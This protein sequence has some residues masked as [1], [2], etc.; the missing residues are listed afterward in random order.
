MKCILVHLLL[1]ISVIFMLFKYLWFINIL[2]LFSFFLE[3]L[4]FKHILCHYPPPFLT[5]TRPVVYSYFNFKNYSYF[6]LVSYFRNI[7]SSLP[8]DLS[9][10]HSEGIHFTP[11]RFIPLFSIAT[12]LNYFLVSCAYVLTTYTYTLLYP[13]AIFG[14][15]TRGSIEN[16]FSPTCHFCIDIS[17]YI[18]IYVIKVI[19]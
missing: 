12:E 10:G 11:L 17:I 19:K 15:K 5:F 8:E 4:F 3:L 9:R 7:L 2:S 14:E 1:R 6:I 18:Q 13:Y 16:M